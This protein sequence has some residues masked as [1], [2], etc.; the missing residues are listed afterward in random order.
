MKK[1]YLNIYIIENLMVLYR[2][3]IKNHGVKELFFYA[4]KKKELNILQT[5]TWAIKNG[6]PA[7]ISGM[8]KTSRLFITDNSLTSS[9]WPTGLKLESNYLTLY[10]IINANGT[11]L[12]NAVYFGQPRVCEAILRIDK[13]ISKLFKTY[14]SFDATPLTA[15][16][17]HQQ[18]ACIEVFL[19]AGAD[20]EGREK[21]YLQTPLMVAASTGNEAIVE[22][23]LKHKANP[24]AKDVDGY[25][26]MKI[27]HLK[28]FDNIV[29][30][31]QKAINQ[32]N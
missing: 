10:D 27:A 17:F 23:L 6:Y 15:A 18:Q 22:L 16:A 20:I 11:I 8:F 9:Y 28:R 21:R 19:K 12:H 32:V 29:Q 13:N 5:I 25:T 4:L 1:A 7:V 3:M 14:N 30:I 31:L 2:K 26:P 24:I